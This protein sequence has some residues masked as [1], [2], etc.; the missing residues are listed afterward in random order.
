MNKKF[1]MTLIASCLIAA[2]ATGGVEPIGTANLAPLPA[3]T[4]VYIYSSD[5]DVGAPFRVVG[6]LSYTDPGKY[7]ILSLESVIPALK[8]KAREAGAN[9]IIIDETHVVKSGIISTGIGVTGRA[10]FVDLHTD[11]QQ[12]HQPGQ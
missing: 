10:I 8:E 12:R 11:A 2:C 4:P 3:R 6:L 5:K 7:Q 9:G 1:F